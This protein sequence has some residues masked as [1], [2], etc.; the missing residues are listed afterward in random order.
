M[1]S[2]IMAMFLSLVA[3]LTTATPILFP[4][5]DTRI[6]DFAVL[7]QNAKMS[8][9][10]IKQLGAG[11]AEINHFAQTVSLSLFELNVCPAGLTCTQK[12]KGIF[13]TLP[14]VERKTGECNIL[15]VTAK[16]DDRPVDGI[17][18]LVTIEDYSQTTCRFFVPYTARATYVTSFYNRLTGKKETSRSSFSLQMTGIRSAV[19]VAAKYTLT[20]G[21]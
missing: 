8:P 1:K 9:Q 16:R 7:Q 6:V 4:Q 5:R 12:I 2:L 11:L 10:H 13:A 17:L 14:I 3:T 15:T 20:G 18:E 19:A 21:Q